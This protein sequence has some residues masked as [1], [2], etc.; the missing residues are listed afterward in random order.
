MP[1]PPFALPPG[2]VLQSLQASDLLAGAW[3]HFTTRHEQLHATDEALA[4]PAQPPAAPT[5]LDASQDSPASSPVP[6]DAETDMV[7]KAARARHGTDMP[8][9]HVT[10]RGGDGTPSAQT[11]IK[12]SLARRVGWRSA[13][14][15]STQIARRAFIPIANPLK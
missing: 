3:S 2:P 5:Q 9:T 13:L 15:R 10:A 1:E 14:R 7:E 4:S 8:S 12:V 6:D 11:R